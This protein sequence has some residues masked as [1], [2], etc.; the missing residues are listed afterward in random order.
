MDENSGPYYEDPYPFSTQAAYGRSNYDVR[1]AFKLF[2]LW[3]P[4]IFRGAH[5][6]AEKVIGG[7]SLSG[8]WNLHSGFPFDPFYNASTN[9]YFQG[10]GYGA[11][12]PAAMSSGFGTSTSNSTFQQATNPNYGG[13]GTQFFP[14]PTFVPGPNFPAG[15]G[16]VTPGIHRNSLTGPGYSDVDLTLSKGFGLPNTRVLGENAKFEIRADMYNVFNKLNIKVDSI[17]GNLGSVQPD[18]T[19]SANPHFGVAGSALG[20]R[21]IQLQARFSF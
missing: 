11:L 2:G 1:N 13:N 6:W 7:W 4:V 14:G 19:T 16:G 21:T 17:D 3:Q 9:L 10:S 20:S 8:I 12:R 15:A 18:G 5:N